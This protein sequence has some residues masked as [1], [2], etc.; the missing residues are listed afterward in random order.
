MTQEKTPI[1]EMLLVGTVAVQLFSRVYYGRVE[2]VAEI[3]KP[4]TNQQNGVTKIIPQ[5]K[6]TATRDYVAAATLAAEKLEN[7]QQAQFAH[8]VH[9]AAQSTSSL[10][11]E[12]AAEPASDNLKLKLA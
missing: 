12:V 6:A 5:M 2:Y 10:E 9:S 8:T 4:W 11:A 1:G 3:G 7:L